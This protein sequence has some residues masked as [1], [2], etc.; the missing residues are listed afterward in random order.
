MKWA[1]VSG[2]AI[3]VSFGAFVDVDPRW[4]L[5]FGDPCTFSEGAGVDNDR[6]MFPSA[7][8]GV[9]IHRLAMTD[10]GVVSSLRFS[11]VVCPP[12]EA[13]ME[14]LVVGWGMTVELSECVCER[15]PA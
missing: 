3:G 1:A 8:L 10:S 15:L 4:R 14:V 9:L 2:I 5:S 11:F 12:R 13:F 7:L 6:G